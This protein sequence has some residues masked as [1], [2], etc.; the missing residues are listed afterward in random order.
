MVVLFVGACLTFP[1]VAVAQTVSPQ[2]IK[3]LLK[4]AEAFEKQSDWEKACDIYEEVLKHQRDGG[5]VR[6]RYVNAVRRLWQTRR[7]KDISYRKEVLSID[8]GQS[9]WVYGK[10]RDL[11]LDQSLDRKKVDPTKLFRK[12]L[13]ELDFALADAS[14]C[15]QYIPQGK[16]PVI[17]EFRSLL[18]KTW[19]TKKPETRQEAVRHIREIA[20]AAQSQLQLPSTVVVMEFTCGACY[21][22]DEYTVYL[23]PNQLRELCQ[24][25]KGEAVGIGLTVV[26]RDG[27]IL[28]AEVAMGSPAYS[29][30]YE[31]DQIISVNK[32]AVTQVPVEMVRD[33]LDG[34]ADSMV[35]LEVLTMQTGMLRE[36][37]LTRQPL[38]MPSV[39]HS[40]VDSTNGVGLVRIAS[41]QENT[42]KDVDIALAQL[43][44]SNMKALVLDLRGNGGG[45]FDSAVE[46]SRRFL[47]SG[48]IATT[49]ELD[50][51]NNIVT[52]TF[53]ARNPA[54]LTLPLIVLIDADTASAAEV[55]AGALKENG[56]AIVV[57]QTSYGKGCTQRLARLPNLPGGLPTG[58]LRLTTA[59]T[60]SPK[61]LPYTNRG[62]TPDRL[63]APAM[64]MMG[65][66][67]PYLEAGREEAVR[68]LAM[69]R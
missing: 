21:A 39:F 9:L 8:Y 37:S 29:K 61:G 67:D 26:S 13:E 68:L 66:Q 64:M 45:L 25:L 48:P 55:L 3:S 42:V 4:Q 53:E 52:T 2:Q 6:E 43:A 12:G 31:G 50:Y 40:F 11:F 27:K 1:T 22:L 20:L 35:E 19:G 24:A 23:T 32:K 65:Q 14:F 44:A 34:P 58:G 5:P 47:S 38:M 56:R 41:F 60:F 18:K 62:V 63:I 10:V 17:A 49:Q 36:L 16:F 15:Q 46:V 7:H 28:V 54:A 57:G 69:L 59:K 51:K 30:V 33:L